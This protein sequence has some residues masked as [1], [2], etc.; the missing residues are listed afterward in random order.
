M[1]PELEDELEEEATE[2]EPFIASGKTTWQ[3]EDADERRRKAQAK[4]LQNT[5]VGRLLARMGATITIEKPPPVHIAHWVRG[6]SGFEVHCGGQQPQTNVV[7]GMYDQDPQS[8]RAAPGR[9]LAFYLFSSTV[10]PKSRLACKR[11]GVTPVAREPF[12]VD[13]G[14]ATALVSFTNDI[15]VTELVRDAKSPSATVLLSTTPSSHHITCIVRLNTKS[16]GLVHLTFGLHKDSEPS[17]VNVPIPGRVS[18]LDSG[19]FDQDKFKDLSLEVDP[20]IAT[21]IG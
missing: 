11:S 12:G 17:R 4:R 10:D 20:L 14:A 2:L 3:M 9:W 5:P 18:F 13:A 1:R 19:P 7:F 6:Q 15:G 21:A 8:R 16:N